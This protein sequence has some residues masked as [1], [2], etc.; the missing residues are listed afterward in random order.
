MVGV[1]RRLT[2]LFSQHGFSRDEAGLIRGIHGFEGTT[3]VN[4]EKKKIHTDRQ[5]QDLD[6][7][8]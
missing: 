1:F 3:R 8:A 4:D 2:I 5:A 6:P 7:S